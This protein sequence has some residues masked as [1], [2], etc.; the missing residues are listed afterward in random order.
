M[1]IFVV[2]Q[3]CDIGIILGMSESCRDVMSG[4]D[5]VSCHNFMSDHDIT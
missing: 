5:V 2:S 3:N 1:N 4:S